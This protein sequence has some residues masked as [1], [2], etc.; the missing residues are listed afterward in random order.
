MRYPTVNE[1]IEVHRMIEEDPDQFYDPDERHTP[2]IYLEK[3]QFLLGNVPVHRGMLH[4]AAYLMKGLV[5]IQAFPDGNRRT[6]HI[7]L[8]RFL[9]TNGFGFRESHNLARRIS[10]ALNRL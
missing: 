5:V 6:C 10:R 3:L 4:Q 1:V 9:K 2:R 7:V 8:N